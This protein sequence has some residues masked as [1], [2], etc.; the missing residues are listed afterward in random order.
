MRNREFY[1]EPLFWFLVICGLISQT[2]QIL[3]GFGI[4]INQQQLNTIVGST[5]VYGILGLVGF[6]I[7]KNY[8]LVLTLLGVLVLL[9]LS[10]GVVNWFFALPATTIIIILLLILVFR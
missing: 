3:R 7:I 2:G 1:Q 9:G 10:M 4:A 5:V 6:I 8:K